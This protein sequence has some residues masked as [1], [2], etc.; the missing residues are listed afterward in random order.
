MSLH[1]PYPPRIIAR[2]DIKAPNVVKGIHLEGLRKIGDPG[3]IAQRYYNEG[4]DE[5][6]FMD[7]VASL[8]GRNNILDV[9]ESAAQNIFVPMTVGGGIRTIDDIVAVLR[10]GADKVAINTAAIGNANFLKEAAERFGSQC[11]VLSI[12][13]KKH[14]EGQWEAYTDN[15][16]ERTGRD[17]ILWAQEAEALGIG[18]ILVTSIDK[19]GT[20]KGF[21]TAIAGIVRSKVNVPVIVCGGAGRAEHVIDLFSSSHAD[22]A[23]CSSIFHYDLCSIP[24]LKKR[25]IEAGVGVRP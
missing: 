7:I 25:L 6:L 4:I 14:G 13:A 17:A 23:V 24:Q 3:T 1:T 2:L 22:A 18:E 16:R 11:I 21:D 8:Y 9:I 5:I 20:K 10:S 19:E 15:G 12:E